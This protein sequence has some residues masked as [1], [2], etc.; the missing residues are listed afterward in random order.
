MPPNSTMR[1]GRKK[2]D[3]ML[4]TKQQRKNCA[5][6]YWASPQAGMKRAVGAQKTTNAVFVVVCVLSNFVCFYHKK[7]WH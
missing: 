3:A 7:T 6:Q 5:E 1:S 2:K 4:P